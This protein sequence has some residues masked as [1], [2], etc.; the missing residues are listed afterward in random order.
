[1]TAFTTGSLFAGIGGIDLAFEAAG[2]RTAWQVEIADYPRAVLAARFPHAAQH[3]DIYDCHSL[4]FVDVLTAGFPCQPFSV[5]GKKRGMADERY[6]VLEMM[7]V[8]AEVSPYVVFLENVPHF[9]SLADGNAFKQL[10]RALASLGYDAQWGHLRASD[11]GAP[12]RRE[13]WFC[14]AYADHE[15]RTEQKSTPLADRMGQCPRRVAARRKTWLPQSR[16]GRNVNGL[17]Y[18]LDRHQFP[19]PRVSRH[20]KANRRTSRRQRQQTARASLRSETRWS[21]RSSIR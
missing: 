19:A 2:F 10:L 21:R 9:A 4:P 20:A 12:H 13:R 15:R 18:R 7:R 16:L 8:I 1:M 11:A 14:V 5:A 17:P 6:M 3:R